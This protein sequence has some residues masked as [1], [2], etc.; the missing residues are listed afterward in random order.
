MNF[1]KQQF[2]KVKE[3][4]VH[5]D[6]IHGSVTNDVV[7]EKNCVEIQIENI[8]MKRMCGDVHVC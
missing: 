1:N 6:K 5:K 7:R 3:S 4:K 8:R 2:R